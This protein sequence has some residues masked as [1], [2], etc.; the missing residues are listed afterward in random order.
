MSH[1][2]Q[3]QEIKEENHDMDS[4][5]LDEPVDGNLRLATRRFNTTKMKSR[6]KCLGKDIDL[7]KTVVD[8][9]FGKA[10]LKVKN[11]YFN[12]CDYDYDVGCSVVPDA[13]SLTFQ[14]I[15]TTFSR[16]EFREFV[17]YCNN[18]WLV[19]RL[20]FDVGAHLYVPTKLIL[21]RNNNNARSHIINTCKNRRAEIKY[22]SFPKIP[23]ANKSS[24][25][26]VENFILYAHIYDVDISK[27]VRFYTSHGN[28][29][30]KKLTFNV[31]ETHCTD[32]DITE[33]M[34]QIRNES[35]E[36]VKH[37]RNKFND[38][39]SFVLKEPNLYKR[40]SKVNWYLDT[41]HKLFSFPELEDPIANLSHLR[42]V[43]RD[44]R[45]LTLLIERSLISL[46]SRFFSSPF[47]D[48]LRTAFREALYA[49]KNRKTLISAIGSAITSVIAQAVDEDLSD[50]LHDYEL[51]DD[52]QVT[53][54]TQI[55]RPSESVS[56]GEPNEDLEL[57]VQEAKERIEKISS[58]QSMSEINSHDALISTLNRPNVLLGPTERNPSKWNRSV[59]LKLGSTGLFDSLRMNVFLTEI[60][61]SYVGFLCNTIK[62]HYNIDYNAE[63][64][65]SIEYRFS[66]PSSTFFVAR[67]NLRC[68]AELSLISDEC[69]NKQS[70]YE[71]CARKIVQEMHNNP[72]Y[73]K[74]LLVHKWPAPQS[75]NNYPILMN[76]LN[77]RTKGEASVNFVHNSE[78]P[79]S[80]KCVV[81]GIVYFPKIPYA[82]F[83]SNSS[84]STEQ[85]CAVKL[86]LEDFIRV[87]DSILNIATPLVD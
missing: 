7:Y 52:H 85:E 77:N 58:S 2:V 23:G 19:V 54:L 1:S 87:R 60:K 22:S 80:L 43:E 35:L 6:S 73:H 42:E 24:F 59:D 70:A 71:S 76:F 74:Y 53:L 39:L 55:S 31:P 78:F 66:P 8:E 48:D 57:L 9:I 46:E 20:A 27:D 69:A 32:E 86:I 41:G 37:D 4:T 61:G 12:S 79:P 10:S 5:D 14:R 29:H 36:K 83:I 33:L 81:N 16:S 18:P 75:N 82:S 45:D 64:L 65:F 26:T 56:V 50:L 49:C 34:E 40:I 11:T 47:R 63:K 44:P 62:K 84:T 25:W 67:C 68:F 38:L 51:P 30:S 17:E 3:L 28:A 21:L 13:E 72:K 15:G